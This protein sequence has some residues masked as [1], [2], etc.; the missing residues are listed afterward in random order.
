MLSFLC[1]HLP[2]F[3]TEF[4][5]IPLESNVSLRKSSAE[6]SSFRKRL[7]LCLGVGLLLCKHAAGVHV[8]PT[9]VGIL[10]FRLKTRLEKTGGAAPTGGGETQINSGIDM[11]KA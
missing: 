9:R 8:S 6:E 2:W 4:S 7:L 1:V 5:P 3:V 10:V 11:R